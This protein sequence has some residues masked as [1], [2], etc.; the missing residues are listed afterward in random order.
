MQGQDDAV[1]DE[2]ARR[3]ELRS[4]GEARPRAS[5]SRIARNTLVQVLGAG[6]SYLATLVFFVILARALGEELFGDFT[7]AL[8]ISVLVGVSALGTDYA[9]TREVARDREGVHDV[10]W[11]S[12]AIRICIGLVGIAFAAG[13]AL[14]AG[15]GGVI[16]LTAAILGASAGIAVLAQAAQAALRGL[17]DMAPIATAWVLQRFFTAAVGGAVVLL[18]G[19]ELIAVALVYLAGAVLG[20]AYSCAV[21]L[22]RRLRPRL[23]V[24]WA[25]ARSLMGTSLPLAIGNVMV[26]ILARLDAVIL[27][28]IKG[29]TAVGQYGAAYRLFEGTAFFSTVFGL[30]A[31]P[32]L[33]RLTRDTTPTIGEA[34]EKG[35][36]A[37]AVLLV[38][39]GTALVLF[40]EPVTELLYGS[41]YSE[42][43]TPLRFLGIATPLWG[44]LTFTMFV[45]A[46]MERQRLIGWVL[47]FGVVVNVALNLA[48]I[49]PHSLDGAAAAMAMTLAIIDAL[50][51]AIAVRNAGP[52]RP[53]RIGV[54]SLVGCV[55]MVAVGLI[56]GTGLVQAPVALLSYCAVAIAIERRYYAGDLTFMWR[57]ARRGIGGD[58]DRDRSQQPAI[59]TGV[60]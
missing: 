46:A 52:L 37:L 18:L 44:L 41:A 11:N 22:R 19:G 20:L 43:A 24:S 14:I 8:S 45:L 26:L 5:A 34:Y 40:A 16:A 12:M 17:E 49:P 60:P 13:F 36:K 51:I 21:L 3:N 57:A 4:S 54:S 50:L 2:A 39:V 23:S 33:S 9:I 27:S 29:N 1:A 31:Y 53:V 32:V 55:V 56:W 25:R 47:A 15:Y 7:F 59:S 30:S 10:F 38:P 35:C 6:I 42:S 28:A 58:I 48:L